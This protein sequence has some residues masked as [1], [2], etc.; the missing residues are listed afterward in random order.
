MS[1]VEQRIAQLEA[2]MAEL[3][4]RYK[5]D[6]DRYREIQ[7]GDEGTINH[8]YNLVQA[9]KRDVDELKGTG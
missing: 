8:L 1:N 9:L 4:Q 2:Q 5:R 3:E 7:V 6:L